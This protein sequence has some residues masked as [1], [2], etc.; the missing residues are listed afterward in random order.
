MDE[1]KTSEQ[2]FSELSAPKGLCII[3][4]DGWDREHFDQSWFFEKITKEE[5]M[6][7]IFRSVC[8]YQIDMEGNVYE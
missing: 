5:Y 4:P 6:D 1:K 7:R 2:W 3:N 8:V